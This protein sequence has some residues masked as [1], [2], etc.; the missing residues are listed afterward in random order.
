MLK[1][2]SLKWPIKDGDE[3]ASR[4]D[5]NEVYEGRKYVNLKSEEQPGLVGPRAGADGRPE[6]YSPDQFFAGC[7]VR[8]SVGVS[9]YDHPQGGKGVG[10]YLNN[11]QFV[12]PGPRLD[13]KRRA[14]D[15]FDVID[16]GVDDLEDAIDPLG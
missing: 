13:N 9:A 10:L 7:V 8:A 3:Y 6:T 14:E 16:E 2:G 5:G 12:K 4:K 1:A 11:L 15:D